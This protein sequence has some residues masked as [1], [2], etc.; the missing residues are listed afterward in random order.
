MSI[1]FSI[2]HLFIINGISMTETFRCDELSLK[3]FKRTKMIDLF[4]LYFVH[5]VRHTPL[6]LHRAQYYYWLVHLEL[7]RQPQF[8]FWLEN[9]VLKYRSGLIL[10]Q[11]HTEMIVTGRKQWL[12]SWRWIFLT[13]SSTWGQFHF[14]NSIWSI[15]IPPQIDQFKSNSKFFNSN[16]VICSNSFF[17]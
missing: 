7:E 3:H 2:I 11:M 6:L 8:K 13:M 12:V 15:P 14:V 16:S 10:L 9:W 5:N 4:S 17:A 1:C